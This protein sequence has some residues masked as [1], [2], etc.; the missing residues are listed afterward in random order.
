MIP[1]RLLR[2]LLAL[3]LSEGELRALFAS[4]GGRCALCVRGGALPRL[5]IDLACGDEVV[6]H[7]LLALLEEK[8]REEASRYQGV[9]FSALIERW[10]K[11]HQELRGAALG[12]LVWALLQHKLLWLTPLSTRIE[13]DVEALAMHSLAE[14]A[15]PAP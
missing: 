7:R 14:R 5:M 11:Q 6:C 13:D 12:G 15:H 8:F 10:E 3:S 1:C 2:F 9:P 4:L